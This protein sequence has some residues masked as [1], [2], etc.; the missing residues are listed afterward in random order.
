MEWILGLAL[1]PIVLCGLMCVGGM[2]LAAFGLR[3]RAG[4]RECCAGPAD[5]LGR[6][7]PARGARR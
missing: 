5:V 1:V 2:A 3:R 7:E 6:D 4:R